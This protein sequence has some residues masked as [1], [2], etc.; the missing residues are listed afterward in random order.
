MFMDDF[1]L[2]M[3]ENGIMGYVDFTMIPSG[4]VYVNQTTGEV[5]CQHGPDECTLNKLLNCAIAQSTS[6]KEGISFVAC[7]EKVKN[8]VL[9][10]PKLAQK[11][12][13]KVSVT[14]LFP[15]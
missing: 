7:I 13:D 11:C 14:K 5:F 15:Q 3:S 9:K 10:N 1:V 2:P 12:A 8:R 4:N 6:Q